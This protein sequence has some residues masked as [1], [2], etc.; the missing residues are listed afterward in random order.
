MHRTV[1]HFLAAIKEAVSNIEEYTTDMS[2]EQFLA[3][4]KTRDAD[5]KDIR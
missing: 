1:L 2:Y 4:K 5:C 3:D